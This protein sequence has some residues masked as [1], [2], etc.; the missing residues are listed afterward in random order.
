M[1]SRKKLIRTKFRGEFLNRFG[2]RENI[3]WFDLLNEESLVKIVNREFDGINTS[4]AERGIKTE[5]STKDIEAFVADQ[6]DPIR[7]ARGL[8]GVINKTVDS[9][10]INTQLNNPD[11]KGTLTVVYDK[12]TKQLTTS[13]K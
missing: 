13:M 6:Y 1:S 11:A 2:G 9:I 4:Y 7:D 5:I 10:I 3:F 12:D 8:P